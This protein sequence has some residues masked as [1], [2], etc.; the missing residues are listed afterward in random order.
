MQRYTLFRNAPLDQ[1][2]TFRVSARAAWLGEVRDST[3]LHELLTRPEA[4]E[5]PVLVLGDGSNVL[6]TR[7]YQGLIIHLATRGIEVLESNE[8]GTLVRVAAGE[9][10]DNF[11]RWSLARGFTG[12]ENLILIPGTVGAAPIQNIGAYG[13]EIR[14]FVE[15][16]EAFDRAD[17]QSGRLDNAACRFAYR[18]S[19]FKRRPHRYVVTSVEFRL[20]RQR[21]LRPDYA[22]IRQELEA[23]KIDEPT[24]L[25]LGRAVERLRRR[26]LPDPT[27]T[28][29]GGSFFKN[30]L[31]SIEHLDTLRGDHPDLPY[32]FQDSGTCKLS[33][34]WLIEACGFKGVREGDAGISEKHALVLVN[35]GAAN[36]AQIWALA[37]HVRQAVADRFGV[38]LEPELVVI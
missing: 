30:P 23:M 36:G 10:W 22:G 13:V 25:D 12:L 6:F 16:V 18:D 26:K 32:Y 7:D 24:P 15:T 11:V 4:T 27:G 31:V 38:S 28:G 2:T 1:R 5:H 20:P 8:K 14:E 19:V 33:A 17:L 21:P 34:A 37:E 29:N 9:N 3:A 35:H